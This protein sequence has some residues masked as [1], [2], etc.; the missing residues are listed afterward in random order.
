[1][2]ASSAEYWAQ[3]KVVRTACWT[4][5]HWACCWAA[6]WEEQWAAAMAGWWGYRSAVLTEIL[7]AELMAD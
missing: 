4:V 6:R 2:V 5:V 7:S 3:T 1:M